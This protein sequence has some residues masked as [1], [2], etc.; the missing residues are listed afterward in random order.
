MFNFDIAISF[1]GKDREQAKKLVSQLKKQDLKVFYDNDYQADLLGKDLYRELHRLY[2]DDA[3]FFV[4]LISEWYIQA[5]WPMHELR[6]AQEREFSD[7]VEYILPIQLDDTMA[8]G[9]PATKGYLDLRKMSALKVATV[10]KKK[11][12]TRKKSDFFERVRIHNNIM[13]SFEFLVNRF[14]LLSQTSKVAEF[15]HFP[16]FVALLKETISNIESKLNKDFS[17][18]IV[19]EFLDYMEMKEDEHINGLDNKS[20]F[21]KQLRLLSSF[22]AFK[23]A[24]EGFSACK[25]S[26]DFDFHYFAKWQKENEK[27]DLTGKVLDSLKDLIELAK[28]E[29]LA[30]LTANVLYREFLK[31]ALLGYLLDEKDVDVDSL[32]TV[33]PEEFLNDYD[34]SKHI[35]QDAFDD[36]A[37]MITT[38]QQNKSISDS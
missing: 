31:I 6:S 15:V 25:Y 21:L 34:N 5:S 24:Y 18:I 10:I 30:P 32:L 26:D 8:P 33:F 19:T 4:P 28:A 37:K 22:S 27:R 2:K 17:R 23:K 3:L 16:G 29:A 7:K 36:I 13:H 1:A 38:N 9:I 12:D 14:C 20:L 35:N 11:V